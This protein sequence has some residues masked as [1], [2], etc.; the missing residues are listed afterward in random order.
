MNTLSISLLILVM[1]LIAQFLGVSGLTP[2]P[3]PRCKIGNPFASTIKDIPNNAAVL[4][5]Y[6]PKGWIPSDVTKLKLTFVPSLEQGVD[7][8][9]WPEPNEHVLPDNYQ[10]KRYPTVLYLLLTPGKRWIKNLTLDRPQPLVVE[11]IHCQHPPKKNTS[12]LSNNKFNGTVVGNIIAE[13]KNCPSSLLLPGASKELQTKINDVLQHCQDPMFIRSGDLDWKK[14]HSLSLLMMQPAVMFVDGT[15]QTMLQAANSV[16]QFL[17]PHSVLE[18]V[19]EPMSEDEPQFWLL[20]PRP[21]GMPG[22]MFAML[23]ELQW[24]HPFV[25]SD[26]SFEDPGRFSCLGRDCVPGCERTQLAGISGSGYS[27]DAFN[28]YNVLREGFMYAGLSQHTGCPV[29]SSKSVLVAC[30]YFVVCVVMLCLVFI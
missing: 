22:H 5:I 19:W 17:A 3:A 2:K 26:P 12:V 6:G 9:I 23:D 15:D 20:M 18:V 27:A 28:V 7:Y 21:L 24:H 11:S 4:Q 1:F 30:Y 14:H 8:S 13:R 25:T 16:D 29:Y 10:V